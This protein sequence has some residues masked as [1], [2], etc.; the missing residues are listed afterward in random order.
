MAETVLE[1]PSTRNTIP[2][3]IATGRHIV[4]SD[5]T[6][7]PS[8]SFPA[9]Y[10]GFTALI[11]AER[12]CPMCQQEVSPHSIRRFEEEEAK[13]WLAKYT[14]QDSKPPGQAAK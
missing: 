8:C 4:L 2:Y 10:S 1:C 13:E 3:C 9:L 12:Q 6:T 14:R 7:C 5:L 11:E